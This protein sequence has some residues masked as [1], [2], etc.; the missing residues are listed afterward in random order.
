MTELVLTIKI[1]IALPAP[2]M[3]VT[4]MFFFVTRN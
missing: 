2:P 3:A 1:I 4:K